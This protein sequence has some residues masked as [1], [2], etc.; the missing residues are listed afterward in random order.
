MERMSLIQLALRVFALI[1]ACIV[2]GTSADLAAFL[3]SAR[4]QAALKV[5]QISLHGLKSIIE[6]GAFTGAWGLLVS[7]IGLA[8][9]FVSAI[10]WIAMVALDA[11]AALFYFADAVVCIS[12]LKGRRASVAR[13]CGLIRF[14]HQPGGIGMAQQ[15]RRRD[16]RRRYQQQVRG[17]QGGHGFPVPGLPDYTWAHRAGVL[18]AEQ[19]V[20]GCI[21]GH[22][23]RVTH[24]TKSDEHNVRNGMRRTKTET[25]AVGARE[26]CE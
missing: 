11:L 4:V 23:I 19:E 21:L 17:R 2:L 18:R 5:A 3:N 7:L 1:C 10:P 13:D 9:C 6:F 22:G 14:S 26:G 24:C 16:P 8:Y 12:S 15:P 20:R 25:G